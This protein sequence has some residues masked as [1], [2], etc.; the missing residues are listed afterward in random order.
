MRSFEERVAEINRR[1][2]KILQ[3]R[4]TR[5]KHILFACVPLVLCVGFCAAFVLPNGSPAKDTA[6]ESVTEAPM[7]DAAMG[8][9][10]CS[11]ETVHIQSPAYE[12]TVTD[13]V[14]VGKIYGV[15][16][17]IYPEESDA[18]IPEKG[19]NG[20][21]TGGRGEQIYGK[22]E[23]YSITFTTADGTEDVYV[24]QENTLTKV[25]TGEVSVLTADQ[26]QQLY[27]VLVLEP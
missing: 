25:R 11:Y 27:A 7:E 15:I 10:F 5:R 6:P 16:L 24:L 9:L 14:S 3:D 21:V 1:S 22:A 8:S 26:Q 23:E 2:E 18:N 4:K 17:D 13:R 12:R 19:N 20:T